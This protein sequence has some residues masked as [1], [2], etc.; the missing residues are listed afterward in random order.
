MPWSIRR[1]AVSNLF[2]IE[3]GKTTWTIVKAGPLMKN[4]IQKA[5]SAQKTS[6]PKISGSVSGALAA[7][8][9]I[10]LLLCN[11]ARENWREYINY[12]EEELQQRTRDV[13]S[14]SVDGAPDPLDNSFTMEAAASSPPLQSG[15]KSTFSQRSPS[16]NGIRM[17]SWQSRQSTAGP[18]HSDRPTKQAGYSAAAI[19]HWSS[20]RPFSLEDLKHI[21]FLAEQADEAL[22]VIKSNERIILEL[23]GHYRTI[24]VPELC[25]NDLK[26][27]CSTEY[28]RF[29]DRID[30]IVNDLRV[31]QYRLITLQSLFSSKKAQVGEWYQFLKLLMLLTN[32]S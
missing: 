27:R 2:D 19:S 32:F 16:T 23:Q 22:L 25:P 17:L 13:L 20:Q 29:N 1:A 10:H 14:K 8:L 28:R 6:L 30:A 18:T 9:E 21:H 11:W 3:T 7:S 12:L 5:L 31:H 26:A 15:M 4:R 24:L